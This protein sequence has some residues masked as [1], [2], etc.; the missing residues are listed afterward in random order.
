L[1]SPLNV[2]LGIA[3]AMAREH[4]L[5]SRAQQD[6]GLVLKSGK[7]LR[8]L[9]NQVL[10]WSKIE[11]G[12]FT[13]TES[14]FDLR[15]LLQELQGMFEL[16]AREKGL[17]FSVIHGPD[18]MGWVRADPVR[19]RQ[20]L[21][22]LV[23]NA[24]KFT[25]HGFVELRVEMLERT[26]FDRGARRFRFVVR[27]SGP[28]IS[29]EE[30]PTLFDAFKQ[31]RAGASAKE[32]SGLGLA[33]SRGFVELM[34]G[35]LELES[36]VGAGTTIRFEVPLEAAPTVDV[37]GSEALPRQVMLAPGQPEYRILVVDDHRAARQLL[38]RLLSPIGFQVREAADGL[39][40]VETWQ[41]WSPHVVCMDE[42]MPVL[43]GREAARRIKAAPGGSSTLIVALTASGLEEDQADLR[44]AGYDAFL[45]KPYS[46]TDLLR[47]LQQYL[48]FRFAHDADS[49]ARTS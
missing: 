36:Q 17:T 20:V 3:Q 14:A 11:A 9:I 33:I 5:S 25:E 46:E 8:T 31:G 28:G 13:L 15:K 35:W 30:I 16:M 37:T 7:H 40:A 2:I 10:D 38:V 44:A 21:V 34:G 49:H 42:R 22:N 12:S 19:L 47:V 48:N 1:R 27:D 6:L 23:G 41:A 24:V 32:G 45:L 4:T 26:P 29:S 18:S 43:D 39:E